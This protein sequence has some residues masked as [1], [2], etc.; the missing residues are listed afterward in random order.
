MLESVVFLRQ[1]I[2]SL[3][4]GLEMRIRVL[5]DCDI[6]VDEKDISLRKNLDQTCSE[7]E[8]ALYRNVL[9]DVR[10]Y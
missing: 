4:Q 8:S 5:S 6:C 10:A 2:E 1:E 9:D 3:H 7:L